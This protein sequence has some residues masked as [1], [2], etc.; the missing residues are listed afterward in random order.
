MR[1]P[2]WETERLRVADEA[3][4][5]IMR[6]A[7]SAGRSLLT[8]PEA[9]AVLVGLWHSDGRH[10][11]GRHAGRGRKH[12]RDLLEQTPSVVVKILSD[13]ISHKSDV[14]GVRLGLRSPQ[15]AR[16]AAERMQQRAAE[17]RPKARLQRLHGA[18]DGHAPQRA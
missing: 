11:G 16:R 1:T 13:D 10:Q 15:E 6:A 5:T 12:R 2:P 3:A 18:A 14:G 8:E 17:L 4:R 9:K 7:A